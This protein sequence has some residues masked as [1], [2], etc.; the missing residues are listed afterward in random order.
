MYAQTNNAGPVRTITTTTHIGGYHIKCHGQN[1]GVI[2]ANPSFGKAP[3]TY[4]WSTGDTSRQINNKPAGIYYVTATD[5]NQFSQTDTFA[6]LEPDS[7][8]FQA[9]LNDFNGYHLIS[10]D[11]TS[12]FAGLNSYGGTPPYKYLWSNGD[13]RAKRFD[14]SAGNYTF[15]ITDANQCSVNG[16]VTLIAPDPVQFNFSNIQHTQCYKSEDGAVTLNISGGLGDF[17]VV[18]SNGSFSLSPNDLPAGYNE[19]RI[20]EQG[21]PI[22]DTGITI[23]EPAQIEAAFTLS[24]YNNGNNVS[25]VDCFNGSISTSVNGGTAPYTYLWNDENQSTTANLSNLNGGD[26]TIIIVDAHACE[27]SESVNL[28][29]PTSKDWSRYGNSNID[30]AEFIGSTDTS[31]VVFKTNNQE[32]LR[33]KGNGDVEMAGDLKISSLAA[34]DVGLLGS[35]TNGTVKP[36]TSHQI[37]EVLYKSLPCPAI[38]NDG[39]VDSPPAWTSLAMGQKYF[40][41]LNTCGKVGINFPSGVLPM[42]ELEVKGSSLIRNNL[43]VEHDFA[44]WGNAQ[45]NGNS[46][47]DGKLGIGVASPNQKLE[48]NGHALISQSLGIGSNVNAQAALHI[49]DGVSNS[50]ILENTQTQDK[51]QLEV[52]AGTSNIISKGGLRLY[53][54]SEVDTTNTSANFI[55]VKNANSYQQTPTR[56]ELF[57]IQNDGTG[58]IKDLWVKGVAS[59]G[60]FPDYVFAKDYK[61]RSL[62]EVKAFYQ[63]HQHL[64]GMPSAK[65]IEVAG[66]ASMSQLLINLTKIVEENTIYLTQQDE[67]IKQLQAE[68]LKL[69]K[70]IE[71]LTKK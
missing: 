17:S 9:E 13:T 56:Q 60:A 3:Y 1:S 32:A 40:N 30:T 7:L 14:L 31:D 21:N 39:S 50:I 37:S 20:F 64:P 48:V 16:S 18:W 58:Y 61:L 25:C 24:Q 62:A 42:A 53:V 57:K 23:N 5:S 63:K 4:L 69:K 22:I 51:L 44:L 15:T 55:I 66:G 6:L 26:Y 49:K 59:N 46:I 19:V 52:T 41:G 34:N 27:I 33:I 65:E 36:L 68:N 71:K 11:D 8:Y 12:G 70:S 38:N 67:Q 29:M 43:T 47:V 35:D 10:H 28:K 54:N 2:S 45:T